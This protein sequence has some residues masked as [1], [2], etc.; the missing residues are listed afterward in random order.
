MRERRDAGTFVRGC[1]L[2]VA[3]STHIRCGRADRA[4][5]ARHQHGRPA[6]GYFSLMCF[7][8]E[9]AELGYLPVLYKYRYQVSS[10]ALVPTEYSVLHW[11]QVCTSYLGIGRF[12]Y[13]VK[14]Q[15]PEGDR[16]ISPS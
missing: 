1:K 11:Y 2:A 16:F 5:S 3:A 10:A 9:I 7:V 8:V 14:E 12:R 4:L 6:P 15:S 13:E